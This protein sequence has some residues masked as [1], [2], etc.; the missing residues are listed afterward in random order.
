GARPGG[1]SAPV[2]PASRCVG[3]SRGLTDPRREPD[4]GEGAH[5]GE[6]V[7]KGDQADPPGAGGDDASQPAQAGRDDPAAPGLGRSTPQY[8]GRVGGN[9][10]LAPA[11]G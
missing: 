11:G 2:F 5:Q 7:A 9:R 8:S 3:A 4:D 6:P 1:R 10:S